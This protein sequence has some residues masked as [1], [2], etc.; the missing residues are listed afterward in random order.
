MSVRPDVVCWY[1]GMQLLP[2][3]FQLQGLRAE[4]MAA[5]LALAAN[6]W[7]WGVAHFEH[8]PAALVAG[9]LRLLSLEATMPDGMPVSL[10]AAQET[11]LELDLAKPVK[12]SE[13]ST[14]TV[15]LAFNPLWQ[16]QR[17]RP[18][19]GRWQSE[20]SEPVPNLDSGL[21]DERV[22]VW[23]PAPRLVTD[24]DKADSV[25]LP[26][27]RV[28]K[29]NGVYKA[30]PD[31]VAPSP[32]VTP[33]SVLG[34]RVL[35]LCAMVREK[36][37]SIGV[38]LQGV[39]L[40]GDPARARVLRSQSAALWAR[41]PEVEGALYS[42]IATPQALHGLLLG[43]AGSWAALDPVNGVPAF[44]PLEFLDLYRGYDEVLDWLERSLKKVREGLRS[45]PFEQKGNVYEIQL[46]SF[47]P[48]RPL[49]VG[50]RMPP[51][52][53]EPDASL[54]LGR[55]II[56]SAGNVADL[57]RQRRPG[58]AHKALDLARQAASGVG[59][60]TRLFEIDTGEHWFNPQLPLQIVSPGNGETFKPWQIVLLI[61][62][63]HEEVA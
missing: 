59:S 29:E 23:K 14:V 10:G 20:L 15:Y 57:A 2:Q 43:M 16:G 42:G 53:P 32:R 27:I 24:R 21:D 47:D 46:P 9:K 33:Q 51:G 44:S 18:M 62:D 28:R 63:N 13:T 26:L 8:D 30:L 25:C 7:Y 41:L 4:A 38:R 58:L 45:V 39:E 6:P 50:L 36:C 11:Q 19:E 17:L 56:A 49:L 40:E 54:W 55:T 22:T 31:F 52:A 3:H 37:G 60:E 48:S 12:D 5:H 35:K 61:D 1:E 34:Q